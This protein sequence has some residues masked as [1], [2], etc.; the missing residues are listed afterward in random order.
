MQDSDRTKE[1][2]HRI[3]EAEGRPDGRHCEH[4]AQAQEELRREDD[5]EADAV[6]G[7]DAQAPDDRSPARQKDQMRD[8]PRHSSSADSTD[9]I[10]GAAA[11]EDTYD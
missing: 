10:D 6:A 2:A 5:L 8:E 4:W 11:D 1:R 9:E 7:D 3:W